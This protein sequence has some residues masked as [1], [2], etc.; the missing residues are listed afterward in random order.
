VCACGAH[1][2]LPAYLLLA[3]IIASAAAFIISQVMLD[4]IQERFFNQLIESGR[5][6]DW[7]SARK[8][9]AGHCVWGQ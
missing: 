4:S 1:E 8:P 7:M 3:I 6:H 9:Y 5:R 2:D